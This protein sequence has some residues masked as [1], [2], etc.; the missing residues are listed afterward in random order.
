M[1]NN[2]SDLAGH[3]QLKSK[4]Y[5]TSL[6]HEALG[7]DLIYPRHFCLSSET[8][9]FV[10]RR[11]PLIGEHNDSIYRKEMGLLEAEISELK[12]SHVI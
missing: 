4:N 11:A 8:D 5:W 1:A 3:P 2:A 12:N 7:L 6:E 10:K 9:N